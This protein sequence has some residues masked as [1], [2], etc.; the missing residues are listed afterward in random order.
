[1]YNHLKIITPNLSIISIFITIITLHLN[2]I[3]NLSKNNNRSFDFLH[4]FE[5]LDARLDHTRALCI[6]PEL[7]DELLD[8]LDLFLLR[9]VPLLSVGQILS[10]H[11]H[12][13]LIVPLKH[14][15]LSMCT[16]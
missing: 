12:E 7:V 3:I 1:M 6:V 10:V 5:H 2:S 13:R 16:L 4:F 8:V 11:L 9:V 14:C 15:C